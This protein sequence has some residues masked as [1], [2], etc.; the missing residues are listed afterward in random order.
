MWWAKR[1]LTDHQRSPLLSRLRI[2]TPITRRTARIDTGPV[3]SGYPGG[4]SHPL[5]YAALPSRTVPGNPATRMQV[6]RAC[7]RSGGRQD[8]SDL[9]AVD[10][11]TPNARAAAGAVNVK[12]NVQLPGLSTPNN[13]SASARL[14]SS[15]SRSIALTSTVKAAAAGDRLRDSRKMNP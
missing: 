2:C 3:A 7:S 11:N 8:R 6:F 10:S 13:S 14:R 12:A 1:V 5:K 4:D 15:T 9:K